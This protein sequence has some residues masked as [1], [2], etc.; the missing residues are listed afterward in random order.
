MAHFSY[1]EDVLMEDENGD[2]SYDEA[3]SD[4]VNDAV[5]NIEMALWNLVDELE[6][7]ISAETVEPTNP[8]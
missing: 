6:Y 8:E 3:I 5:V 1:D 2:V 7:I 4:A